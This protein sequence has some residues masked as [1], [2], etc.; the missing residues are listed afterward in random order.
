M[1][2]SAVDEGRNP[3]GTPG[4]GNADKLWRMSQAVPCPK[5]GAPS[6]RVVIVG[7]KATVICQG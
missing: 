1:S 5:C 3:Y 7:D 2:G 4:K 6:R